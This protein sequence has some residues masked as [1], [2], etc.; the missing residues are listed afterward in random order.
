MT[1]S[2]SNRLQ[3]LLDRLESVDQLNAE[4]VSALIES[5]RAS[6]EREKIFA[7]QM[8]RLTNIQAQQAEMLHKLTDNMGKLVDHL[9]SANAAIERL[10]RVLDYLMRRDAERGS[11]KDSQDF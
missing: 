4:Q 7:R 9:G 3:R 5:H 8:E 11:P 1:Q 6:L 2:D 10:D